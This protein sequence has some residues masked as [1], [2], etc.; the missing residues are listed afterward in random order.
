MTLN[1]IWFLPF[2]VW[3][4]G[5]TSQGVANGIQKIVGLVRSRNPCNI[6]N[7]SRRLV[8]FLFGSEIRVSGSDFQTRVSVSLGFYHSPPLSQC[9]EQ[10]ILFANPDSG[11]HL[12]LGLLFSCQN[13][14]KNKHCCCF[15]WVPLH[16]YSN[17]PFLISKVNCVS[18]SG[19]G[20]ILFS[21]FCLE[22]GSNIVSL[23][24]GTGSDSQALSSTPPS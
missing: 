20:H 17:T 23:Q 9:L 2:R 14:A 13:R 16:V 11:T 22:Q 15:A 18:H 8:F 1:R 4:T 24:T 3:N 12:G 5:S 19:T 10:G 21:L 7:E 6:S